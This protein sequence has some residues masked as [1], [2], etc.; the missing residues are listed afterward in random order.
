[1]TKAVIVGINKY[2]PQYPTLQGCVNDAQ[3][4]IA[5]LTAERG[6]DPSDIMPLYDSRATK[7]AIVTALKDMIAASSP[8][9]HLLFHYSGHGSQIASQDVN[10]PDG[11]DECLCPYDFDFADRDTA[12]TDNEMGDIMA[13]VPDGTAL[14]IVLDSCHSGDMQKDAKLKPR[15]IPVPPDLALRFKRRRLVKRRSLAAVNA[16]L[17][18]AC[19]SNETAADTSYGNRPNGAFTYNWLSVVREGATS[20]LD[21]LVSA[22]TKPLAVAP[23]NMHP[24]VDGLAQLEQATFLVEPPPA[25]RSLV[26]RTV[27]RSPAQVVFDESWSTKVLGTDIGVDLQISIVDGGFDFQLSSMSGIPLR[28]SFMINGNST[29]Q[30]GLGYGFSLI[31]ATSNWTANPS[32]VDFDLA[33]RVAPPFFGQVTVTQQ[34]VS[35]P[36]AA[37]PRAVA[38]PTSPADLLAMIQLA[39]LGYSKDPT[40]VPAQ[41]VPRDGDGQWTGIAQIENFSGGLFGCSYNKNT[42]NS[43]I[44]PGFIRDHVEV[45]L[46]PPNSGNVHFN[47]WNDSDPHIGGFEFH[48]GCSSCGGGSATFYLHCVPDP[49]IPRTIVHA[50]IVIPVTPTTP[51]NGHSKRE[52]GEGLQQ[53]VP[54]AGGSIRA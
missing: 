12:F 44:P 8:G 1:M 20:S 33:I 43:Y 27:T 36:V 9:D 30:V 31:L 41:V 46:N 48:V 23:Y 28:W 29:Q 3:D 21:D 5:Y 34:H 39:Q 54:E 13:S 22:V 6:L 53:P 40:P 14:T 26:P 51:K 2:P 24:Q 7:S 16:A 10:E 4:V 50:P 19:A 25:S 11:L 35:I 17:V 45:L 38:M 18:S 47:K 52:L 15:F 42:D 32:Q 49:A 37:I